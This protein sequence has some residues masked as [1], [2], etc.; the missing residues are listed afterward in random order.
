MQA[1]ADTEYKDPCIYLSQTIFLIFHD[2]KH[3]TCLFFT[4]ESLQT[5]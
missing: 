2:L 1:N 3:I 4:Q 5:N